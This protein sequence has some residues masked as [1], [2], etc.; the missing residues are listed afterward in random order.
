[1]DVSHSLLE[2]YREVDAAVRLRYV[3]ISI[4]LFL[5]LM[6]TF[7]ALDWVVYPQL[8]DEMLR[9]RFFF[10][11]L[12]LLILLLTFT[13]LAAHIRAI[14]V[15]AAILAGV[16]ISWLVAISEGAASPY[17]AGL[18]LILVVMSVMLPWTL[19]ET[20]IVCAV[21]ALVYVLA[22]WWNGSEILV[23]D[24]RTA[25]FTN[26]LFFLA[27]TS[28][29]CMTASYFQSIRRFE[30]FRL[31]YELDRQNKKLAELDREKTE[32]FANVS[33][34][35]RTP[36]TLILA[37]VEEILSSAAG[38]TDRVAVRLGVVRDNC[39][40]LLKLVNDLLDVIRLEEGKEDLASRPVD[41]NTVLRGIVDGMI[42]LADTKEISV[43]PRF[44]SEPLFVLGDLRALE[45]VVVNLLSNAVKFTGKG[46]S[47]R[48]ETWGDGS[49]A[50]FQVADTGIGIPP[51]EQAHIFD[52]F[53]QVDGS[54][55][56]RYRGTGLGL[57]LVKELT[58]KM[59]GRV[60]VK[61]APGKGTTMTVR[62]PL[63]PEG[64]TEA[65]E[66]AFGYAEDD[67]LE[68]LHRLAE[69][70]G[71]LTIDGPDLDW[72]ADESA[73]C[74]KRATVLVVEDEPDMRRYLVD[75]L[76]EEYRVVTARTGTE[77]LRTARERA[78]ELVLLDLMLP[79]MDGLEVCRRIREDAN[80]RSQKIMLLTARVDEQ[81]KLTALEHGADDFLT[82]PFSS[83]EVRTRLRNLLATAVLERDLEERNRRL[84][85]ALGELEATQAQLIHSE[86]LN[87][88]G[89]LSA[90]LLHEIN[91]PLN[92]SLTALQLIRDDPA[93]KENDLLNEVVGDINEGMQRIRTIV[94]D[95]RAFAYPSEAERRTPFLLR[96]AVESAIRFTSHELKGLQL[97][98]D[99]PEGLLVVGSKSLIT[100]VLVNLLSNAVR[101]VAPVAGQRRGEVRLAA[102]AS[103]GR[104]TVRVADNGV[105]M[106]GE[107]L[108]RVFDPFF[109]TRDVGEGMGLGLS[110]CHTIVS[111]HGGRL[112]AHSQPDNGAEF[113]FDLPGEAAASAG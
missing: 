23:G 35:L 60:D 15:G 56:R 52:R 109:T 2:A 28:I 80:L 21:T 42:H 62:L 61:S 77:G 55:T 53:R 100:Q 65:D 64:T 111:N 75:I 97:M 9:I 46:G 102:V 12:F 99:V 91:N 112:L 16:S 59:G 33:H 84:Q 85:K 79:E 44:A 93:V 17:Y 1:M 71:G 95:L 107:T 67:G 18:N 10:D 81:S 11:I 39:L 36:L 14:G 86:K 90:G 57:A 29:I 3:R 40:R 104:V 32:F 4:V 63:A 47:I 76:E 5:F 110:I 108:K 31:R 92:Y 20:A 22:C 8:F 70:R 66:E 68:R 27:A 88:L 74:G 13:P 30:E 87:A 49:S 72:V 103:S 43:S 41:L 50:M 96:E 82:K 34:E 7:S 54:S 105:G 94:S 25:A 98:Q 73:D 19:R 26:N 38:I 24:G 113:V 78:P 6:P 89:S 58:E 48:V 83:V 106:D 101:A 51:E 45:K 37:P 69:R